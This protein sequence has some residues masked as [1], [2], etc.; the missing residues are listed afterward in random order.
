[1]IG[2]LLAPCLCFLKFITNFLLIHQIL[3]K[4]VIQNSRTQMLPTQ[5]TYLIRKLGDINMPTVA[6][7]FIGRTCT[8][9]STSS[10]TSGRPLSVSPPSTPTQS[11]T[12]SVTFCHQL[13]GHSFSAPTSLHPGSGSA[14]LSCRRASP[15]ADITSPSFRHPRPTTSITHSECSPRVGSV[16]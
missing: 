6:V 1:M 11:S 3:N 16:K 10:T 4:W 13:L 2:G 15:T 7:Y 9:E 12:S 14:S 5:C 8:S